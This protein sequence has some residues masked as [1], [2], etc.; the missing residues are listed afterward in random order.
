V[1]YSPLLSSLQ[2]A[3]WGGRQQLLQTPCRYDH[4]ELEDNMPI[5]L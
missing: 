1:V 4:P 2:L 3:A 5:Q